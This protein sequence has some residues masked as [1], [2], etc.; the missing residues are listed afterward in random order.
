M[1]DRRTSFLLAAAVLVGCTSA[2]VS[3]PPPSR[4]ADAPSP[5][6]IPSAAA[7]P[8]ADAPQATAITTPGWASVA[9]MPT[10]HAF[11]TATLLS[12]GTVLVAGGLIQDRLDG[13]V[14]ASVEAYD[15]KTASWTTLGALTVPRWGHTATLLPDGTLLVTGSHINS[16]E[17]LASAELFDPD[18]TSWIATTSMAAGRGGHT[19]TL[20][21]DGTVLVAG[22]STLSSP[23]GQSSAERYDPGSKS[24]IRA[25]DMGMV[26]QGHTATLLADGRVLVVGGGSE[27]RLAEGP[28]HSATAELYDPASG[29]WTATGSLTMA[30]SGHT[31]TALPDGRVLVVG[32]SIG[33]EETARS[34]ELFDPTDGRWT[35]VSSMTDA[36]SMHTATLLLDGRVLV[37]G[38]IG[39]GSEPTE[40]AS[41]EIYDATSRSW[42]VASSMARSRQYHS[43][44]RLDD[45]R[46][47]VLGDF[48]DASEASVE[49]YDPVSRS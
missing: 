16:A 14:S 45:G 11:H 37:V 15:P 35:V 29:R 31:A 30:R 3:P 2:A 26:R 40:L 47:L 8:T 4:S 46:L 5:S 20:L 17:S 18:R 19:A 33:D 42:S 12:D 28:P 9:N 24:W 38:G 49:V 23:A 36:R 39:L 34:A 25:T 1:R 27:V 7:S 22:G 32:G 21:P 43:A 44:T 41:A 10:P 13:M 6:P 48:D